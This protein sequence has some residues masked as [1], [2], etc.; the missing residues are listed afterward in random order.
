[1]VA[2]LC[3]LKVALVFRNSQKS[4]QY[5]IIILDNNTIWEFKEKI[6]QQRHDYE[7]M[8]VIFLACP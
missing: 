2:N 5:G 1:M 6:Q 8:R 4:D 7:G 3:F